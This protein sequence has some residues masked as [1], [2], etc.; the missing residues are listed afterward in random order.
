VFD[1]F[2][3]S[4]SDPTKAIGWHIDADVVINSSCG[5]LHDILSNVLGISGKKDLHVHAGLGLHQSWSTPLS[6]SSL[7]LSGILKNGQAKLCEGVHLTKIGV[8]LLGIG[9]YSLGLN[10]KAGMKYGFEILG[11][12]NLKVPGSIVP[13]H[14]DYNFTESGRFAL[15]NASVKGNIWNHALGIG[16]LTVKYRN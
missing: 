13:L 6:L 1:I 14:L 10:A 3:S 15:L 4:N 8:V 5:V 2:V 7:T 9:T 16:G 11:E 12:M